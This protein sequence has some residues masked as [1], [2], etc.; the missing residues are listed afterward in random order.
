MSNVQPL[1][2]HLG[3][4]DKSV[5][6]WINTDITPHLFIGRIPL[7]AQLMDMAGLMP[8]ERLEQHRS[9]VFSKLR[10]MDL[11]KP[12]PFSDN[13][14]EAFFSSH[15]LEHL[16]LNEVESLLHQMYRCLVPGGVVRVSVPDLDKIVATYRRD[17]PSE[18]LM[19]IF[20]APHRGSVKNAHHCGFSAPFLLELFRKAGFSRAE[21]T[22][23]LQGAC[24]DIA[25][26]DN[27]PDESLFCEAFK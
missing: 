6:G 19:R 10:Y 24:P 5:D 21:E 13:S 22:M 8:P 12:L 27:R 4:F 11:T 15:V 16:F 17:D 25:L 1:K 23:F 26:L 3:A 7:L 14:V 2:V 9:G 18:F 20:E